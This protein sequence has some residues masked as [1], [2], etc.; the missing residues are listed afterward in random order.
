MPQPQKPI[1][2]AEPLSQL[3]Y[4]KKIK[5]RKLHNEIQNKMSLKG[6]TNLKFLDK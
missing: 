3:V 5:A 4:T 1:W 2:S 6:K